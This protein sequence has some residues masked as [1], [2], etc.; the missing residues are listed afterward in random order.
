GGA[1]LEI[2]D[3]RLEMGPRDWVLL[4]AGT[5]HRLVA[6]DPGTS[7]LAVTRAPAPATAPAGAGSGVR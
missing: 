7:W 3:E 4:P 6:T 5:P 1:T 2:G